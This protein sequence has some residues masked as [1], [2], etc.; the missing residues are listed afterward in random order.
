M[1]QTKGYACFTTHLLAAAGIVLASTFAAQ[2]DDNASFLPRQIISSTIPAN[3]DL[4]PYG[5]VFVPEGFPGG[6]LTPGDVLVSNFNN[7]ANLQGRGTTIIRLAPNGS[8]AP[9]VPAGQSGNATT[10]FA[11]PQH[12]LSTALG[13]LRAGLV[14]VGN[15]PTTDGTSN[16]VRDGKLQIVGDNGNLLTTL[17]DRTFL[18]S[19]WDLTVNDQGSRAQIFVSHVLSGVVSRLD[20]MV[21]ASEFKVVQSVLV[22]TG[23][24]HRPDPSAL[25]LGPTGLAYDQNADVLYVASTADNAIFAVSG[26]GKAVAPVTKGRVVFSD[27]HLH[28]PLGLVFAPNGDLITSNGDAVNPDPAHPSEIIEFTKSGEFIGE[29]NLDAGLGAAFG[30]ATVLTQHPRFNFAA[31]NDGTNA[32]VVYSLP[33]SGELA[34]R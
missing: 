26:A 21:S 14:V 1:Q 16:T 20:V 5:V 29:Y 9:S 4:N 24:A 32:V 22:A 34:S 30:L 6:Q 2:A 10:F 3:G 28:G 33:S 27:P 13:A 23:Y 12:G 11:S 17:T 31:V 19:P 18:D 8:V 25:V 15:V 7:K